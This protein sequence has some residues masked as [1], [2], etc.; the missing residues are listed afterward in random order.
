MSVVILQD[1]LF[2]RKKH[3]LA[4]FYYYL[5]DSGNIAICYID[6]KENESTLNLFAM[7]SQYPIIVNFNGN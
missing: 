4:I 2:S 6:N 5:S 3:F 1:I 7:K